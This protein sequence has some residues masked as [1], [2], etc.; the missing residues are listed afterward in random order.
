M[1]LPLLSIQVTFEP[2]L[3]PGDGAPRH[4]ALGVQLQESTRHGAEH[5]VAGADSVGGGGGRNVGGSGGSRRRIVRGHGWSFFSELCRCFC[6]QILEARQNTAESVKE[7]IE[8]RRVSFFIARRKDASGENEKQGSRNELVSSLQN[9][10]QPLFLRCGPRSSAPPRPPRGTPSEKPSEAP[11]LLLSSELN[12]HQRPQGH[13]DRLAKC[14]DRPRQR[15][16]QRRA[17]KTRPRPLLP[18]RACSWSAWAIFVAAPRR[19]P[20][21]TTWSGRGSSRVLCSSTLAARCVFRIFTLG[22]QEVLLAL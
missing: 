9:S 19:R 2:P 7:C 3:E 1:P 21:W 4:A 20:C 6:L 18:K 10:L 17:T 15:E 16:R 13:R 22:S 8:R 11:P 12:S 5:P 14:V